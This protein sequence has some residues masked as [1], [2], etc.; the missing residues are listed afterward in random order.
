M[1]RQRLTAADVLNIFIEQHRLCSPLDIMADPEITLTFDTTIG[2]W[3]DA[4]DLISWKPLAD[5][6]NKQFCIQATYQEWK[7]VLEPSYKAT[8]KQVCTL[9]A[10]K[11]TYEDIRPVKLFGTEC[12]S[13]AV[14]LTLKKYLKRRNVDVDS[15]R[16][17]TLINPY[18]KKH[19][20]EMIEQISILSKG[21]KVFDRLEYARQKSGF[22]NAINIFDKDRYYFLT[23]DIKTFRDITNRVIA[24]NDAR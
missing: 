5:F 11:T 22:L 23:G 4:M 17:S 3:R 1:I 19:F 9:I 20:S 12:L 13:A 24:L 21:G 16:P 10:K 15:M 7:Q 8:L 18:L 14:F 6:L 2:E